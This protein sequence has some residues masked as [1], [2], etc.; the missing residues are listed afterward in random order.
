MPLSCPCIIII[1]RVRSVWELAIDEGRSLGPLFQSS[2]SC[3][4]IFMHVPVCIVL[5]ATEWPNPILD[6][7]PHVSI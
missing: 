5:S 2:K 6:R 3:L 1:V 4:L 7:C